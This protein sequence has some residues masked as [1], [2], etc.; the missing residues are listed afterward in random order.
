MSSEERAEI[1][2]PESVLNGI[3]YDAKTGLFYLTG[4]LCK[5]IF[6]GRFAE[7]GR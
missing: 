7:T 6:T 5:T 2:T 3:A 4:K 1:D